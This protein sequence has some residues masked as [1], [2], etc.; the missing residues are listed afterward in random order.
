MDLSISCLVVALAEFAGVLE[1]AFVGERSKTF[2]TSEQKLYDMVARATIEALLRPNCTI[3]PTPCPNEIPWSY[4]LKKLAS[5][6]QCAAAA[7]VDVN[8][9][10]ALTVPWM[11]ELLAVL[12]SHLRGLGDIIN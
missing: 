8:A 6:P 7:A 3:Y 2:S 9:H 4:A 10:L 11:A 5:S 1:S 12:T